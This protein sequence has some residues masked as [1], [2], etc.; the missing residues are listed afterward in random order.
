MRAQQGATERTVAA[1]LQLLPPESRP[2]TRQ[3]LRRGTLESAER[4][5]MARESAFATACTIAALFARAGL[6]APVVSIGSISAG[7]AGKTPFLIM[8][9]E[10]LK[11]RGLAFDVLSRGYG[12]RTKGVALVDPNGTPQEFGDEPLL[13]ARKLGVPVIVGEDRYAAGQFAEQ[14]FGPQAHLLD[15]GFQHRR[16]GAGL[17]HRAAYG[18]GLARF[19]A[20]HRTTARAA[21]VA[22][23]GAT[24]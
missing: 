22:G 17:R 19:A 7:G 21:V 3:S 2:G 5:V 23:A 9:G 6:Q 4:A 10:L 8:L 12:R 16:S 1:L 24:Q 15:D 14:K 20:A 13:I 18:P 11:D